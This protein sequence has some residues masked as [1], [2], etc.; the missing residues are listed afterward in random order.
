VYQALRAQGET[1]PDLLAAALLHDVGKARFPLYV[2]ERVLIVLAERFLPG[3]A[4][5]WGD[6]RPESWR[7]P[8]VV[9]RQ[10]PEWGAEMV[11][12]RG[13]SALLVDI[14]RRHQAEVSPAEMGE[15]DRLICRLQ[16]ADSMN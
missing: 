15:A 5:R 4:A 10:H 13:G 7:R 11:A 6:A 14:I 2:W 9:A 8:F 16:A 3:W 1:H 12:R